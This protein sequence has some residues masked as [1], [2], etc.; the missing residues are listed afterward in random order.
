MPE[1]YFG[2]SDTQSVY[3][4]D[5]TSQQVLVYLSSHG[6][7]SL[8]GLISNVAANS[9]QELKTQ[10]TECLGPESSGLVTPSPGG[11][12]TIDGEH[13]T[14]LYELTDRGEQFVSNHDSRLSLPADFKELT[15]T[16]HEIRMGVNSARDKS[17]T[18]DEELHGQLDELHHR[19]AE[20]E[21]Q[22][23]NYT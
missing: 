14:T 8:H 18:L 11:Q 2:T 10:I 4:I 21:D 20:V 5:E 23:S 1:I 9:E 15:D 16:V 19:L 3:R 6:A 12:Q 22:L 7:T 13:T 17:S